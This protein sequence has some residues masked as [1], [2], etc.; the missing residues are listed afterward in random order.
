M[1]SEHWGI[2]PVSAPNTSPIARWHILALLMALC[3]ISHFNRASMATA[4]DTRIMAQFAI[5]PEKMGVVYSAYLIIYTIFMVPG[6]VLTDRFGP[7]QALFTMG[8]GS[9][10]FGALTGSL[11]FFLA[12]GAQLWIG[13]LLVRSLMGL[14]TTPLHPG[15]ASAVRDWFPAAQRSLANGLVTCA[16]LLAYAF[17]HPLFG[18]LID[19][20]DWPVAF[21]ISA[22]VAAFIAILWSKISGQQR[23]PATPAEAP[24]SGLRVHA[25]RNR[26]LLFLTLSYS[27]VGYFQYLF[28][29]WMH[30]YFDT[31]L[32]LGEVTSRYYAALPNFTMALAMPLGGWLSDRAQSFFGEGGR[33]IVPAAGMILSGILLA[34]GIFAKEVYWIVTW[35]TLSLGVLGLC[36]G[37][38]WTMAVEVGGE[39][40]ATTASI[41]NTGGNGI[42]LLAPMLTPMISAHLGW[43]WGIGLGAIV[44]VAGG[45]CWIGI[46]T[47]N[48]RRPVLDTVEATP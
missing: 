18:A 15:C 25:W 35:F 23:A 22:C 43:A 2:K 30:Y 12:T 21:M 28:F 9:A 10:V 45:L 17:V 47:K 31:I 4:A 46:D 27:A 13:L 16:A 37:S 7:Y 19:R 26:S 40:G 44:A 36:E 32:H 41:M 34:I 29:Y 48:T 38:F 3:F 8:V 5:S 6:G 42:G 33:R 24:S 1:R 11:G 20:F 14:T 39:D